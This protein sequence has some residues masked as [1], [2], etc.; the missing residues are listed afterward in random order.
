MKVV[1]F[2]VLASNLR[3]YKG[4]V[5]GKSG[6]T[7]V[8]HGFCGIQHVGGSTLLQLQWYSGLAWLE[9]LAVPLN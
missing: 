2:Q 8:L 6:K 7:G 5:V 9:F 3:Y 1:K 4:T